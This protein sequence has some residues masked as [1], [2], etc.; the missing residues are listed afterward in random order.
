[1]PPG[2]TL[3]ST[4][5]TFLG[6]AHQLPLLLALGWN[7]S[8]SPRQPQVRDA[9]SLSLTMDV[10]GQQ[11]EWQASVSARGY[12]SAVMP[13]GATACQ[14]A[15][16]FP[17][18]LNNRD[19]TSWEPL[20]PHSVA[21]QPLPLRGRR[22][23]QPLGMVQQSLQIHA[24]ARGSFPGGARDGTYWFDVLFA[25]SSG[26][27][28][29]LRVPLLVALRS[30]VAQL[31]SRQVSISAAEDSTGSNA[32]ATTLTNAGSDVLTWS[33]EPQPSPLPCWLSNATSTDGASSGT[34]QPDQAVPLVFHF[35]T[36]GMP[37]G[38]FQTDVLLFTSD[39]AARVIRLN[40]KLQV[41]PL[42]LCPA[43]VRLPAVQAESPIS[44]LSIKI[45]NVGKGPVVLL[46]I[47]AAPPR[48]R[49]LLE[50]AAHLPACAEPQP[51]N[52]STGGTQLQLPE[53]SLRILQ[54]VQQH[55]I[56]PAQAHLS[57]NA[58]PP[59]AWLWGSVSPASPGTVDEQILPAA[60]RS[61][62]Q[63][64]RELQVAQAQWWQATQMEGLLRQT[65]P[66]LTASSLP[67]TAP[68]SPTT[69]LAGSS[70]DV[71]LTAL[72]TPDTTI[73]SAVEQVTTLC[74]LVWNVNKNAVELQ[75]LPASVQVNQ[76]PV[77][78]SRSTVLQLNSA[79]GAEY[80]P[81]FLPND[82]ASGVQGLGTVLQQSSSASTHGIL[83]AVAAFK[84]RYGRRKR[85]EDVLVRFEA[86]E[87]SGPE[88]TFGGTH[89]AKTLPNAVALPLILRLCSDLEQGPL[90]PQTHH[91]M[92]ELLGDWSNDAG[93]S[94][95]CSTLLH[96]AA[97]GSTARLGRLPEIT[98]LFLDVSQPAAFQL[99]IS[100]TDAPHVQY[101]R[102]LAAVNSSASFVTSTGPVT[103]LEAG[104]D[105]TRPNFAIQPDHKWHSLVITQLDSSAAASPSSV[106]A[107]LPASCSPGGGQVGFAGGRMCSCAPGLVRPAGST[108]QTAT[109]QRAT[110]LLDVQS[111]LIDMT[112]SAAVRAPVLGHAVQCGP[113][114]PGFKSGSATL[115]DS[116]QDA[117]GVCQVCPED[118]YAF[119]GV[120]RCMPCPEQGAVCTEGILAIS[121]GYAVAGDI[122]TVLSDQ[123]SVQ[124][125][126]NPS[127]SLAQQLPVYIQRCPNAM[128]CVSQLASAP[129]LLRTAVDPTSMHSARQPYG[130]DIWSCVDPP[131]ELAVFDHRGAKGRS[132]AHGREAQAATAAQSGDWPWQSL[133]STIPD[134]IVP[135]VCREGH[136]SAGGSSLCSRCEDGFAHTPIVAGVTGACVRCAQDGELGAV[137]FFSML[138]FCGVMLAALLAWLQL[139]PLMQLQDKVGR[140]SE[141]GEIELITI[142]PSPVDS[143]STDSPVRLHQVASL[144]ATSCPQDVRQPMLQPQ[145]L[146]AVAW[147]VLLLH[148]ML[149]GIIQALFVSGPQGAAKQASLQSVRV[150]SGLVLPLPLHSV[151]AAC[152]LHSIAPRHQAAVTA[153][154]FALLPVLAVTMAL[155]CI[156]GFQAM[157][158]LLQSRFSFSWRAG[159]A[160]TSMPRRQ[161]ACQVA[162]LA[163]MLSIPTALHGVLRGVTVIDSIRIG[164]KGEPSSHLVSQW[165]L[166]DDREQ[167]AGIM[168]VSWIVALAFLVA[169]LSTI[170]Q[171]VR[172]RLQPAGSH[173]SSCFR[174]AL[175]TDLAHFI[176]RADVRLLPASFPPQ[177]VALL[178]LA[179]LAL[180]LSLLAVW[181]ACLVY[182]PSSTL[183]VVTTVIATWALHEATRVFFV[184]KE[185]GNSGSKF[186]APSQSA[187]GG[188]QQS[189]EAAITA[190]ARGLH[191]DPRHQARLAAVLLQRQAVTHHLL[192]SMMF[193]CCFLQAAAAYLQAFH[194]EAVLS[195]AGG[196]ALAPL[197]WPQ[198]PIVV[199][200]LAFWVP[201]CVCLVCI[202]PWKA[203][204]VLLFPAVRFILPGLSRAA[205]LLQQVVRYGRPALVSVSQKAKSV[206]RQQ[207]GGLGPVEEGGSPTR[208]TL[209]AAELKAR[210][211]RVAVASSVFGLNR[212]SQSHEPLQRH[213]SAP[214]RVS[215]G[216][217]QLFAST[218]SAS[219][220]QSRGVVVR[221]QPAGPASS[222]ERT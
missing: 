164:A 212:Y 31:S 14:A 78:P 194:L 43:S 122:N 207:D 156:I 34:L 105:V 2:R 48:A 221:A 63:A 84:D 53:A 89:S 116:D 173:A 102:E 62:V 136:T 96:D 138:A 133:S 174:N 219:S 197:L 10:A 46:S 179:S 39:P 94:L 214:R 110:R 100:I 4:G 26:G 200:T 203:R 71:Q 161:L 97:A 79:V 44:S 159:H 215:N 180:C 3:N 158:V 57:A 130:Q 125:G 25:D 153:V 77:H 202:A 13:L 154:S 117:F 15:T 107:V 151:S 193:A 142:S 149:S 196:G 65:D 210:A 40:V 88:G 128:A 8:V 204:G 55:V 143:N 184:Q 12:T 195:A 150:A 135:S 37:A 141:A 28:T 198:L 123:K 24:Q 181:A 47:L 129:S 119:P 76:G 17:G 74:V 95:N 19:V 64:A 175:V 222:A 145:V 16:L 186:E 20:Q 115:Q 170:V 146:R 157:L 160:F 213:S 118:T 211:V 201:L 21:V 9:P 18:V 137:L 132:S 114:S 217:K 90:G 205:A 75:V 155:V 172:S 178:P 167:Q 70:A 22:L 103:G 124:A 166:S 148:C 69:M 51:A 68:G 112:L 45:R 169:V 120:S 121:N 1:L 56:Q 189:L 162:A 83:F 208:R 101:D 134:S 185:F 109:V 32:R 182:P 66:P 111:T 171:S 58:A 11:A 187:E 139:Q 27:A 59:G 38:V 72:Y 7:S 216:R 73:A 67:S 127:D 188:V 30:P 140:S 52:T 60:V 85:A 36:T 87:V 93:D 206:L 91:A 192:F 35:N 163:S 131:C 98:G 80:F 92:I 104:S 126:N 50:S 147:L 218:Q 49:P 177:L 99:S 5:L 86:S 29:M 183:A 191:S 23:W 165:N 220:R 106:L 54:A 42:T 176:S 33:L 168:A 190:F 113:C 209:S 108:L 6:T 41:F 82:G 81:V 199:Y 144:A 152:L 61:A